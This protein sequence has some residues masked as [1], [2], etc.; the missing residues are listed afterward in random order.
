FARVSRARTRGMSRRR[1]R[2]LRD[3]LPP[4]MPRV[5][6]TAILTRVLSVCLLALSCACQSLAPAPPSLRV[7]SFNVRVPVDADGPDRWELRRDA[8]VR[9]IRDADP[10]LLGTQELVRE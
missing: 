7:M 6:A 4:T 2:G 3:R 8:M 5:P 9:T 1:S 10:V